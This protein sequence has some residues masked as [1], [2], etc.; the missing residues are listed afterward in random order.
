MKKCTY[1]PAGH[2][3]THVITALKRLRQEEISPEATETPSQNKEMVIAM[4]QQV[5]QFAAKPDDLSLVPRVH[6]HGGRREWIL[7]DCPLTTT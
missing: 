1:F 5:K 4:A 2:G 6:P 7:T 3:G